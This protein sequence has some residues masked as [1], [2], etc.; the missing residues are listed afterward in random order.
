M[1]VANQG[2][3]EAPSSSLTIV[4]A[5]TFSAIAEVPTGTGAHGVVVEPSG[6]YAYV[7]DIYADTVTIV[8]VV[9]ATPAGTI[10][11][12]DGPNG[13]SFSSARIDAGVPASLT[14]DLRDTDGMEGEMEH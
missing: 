9:S 7:T 14:V 2:T 8:D 10:A 13:I 4:D 5:T 12:G 1:L 6:R 11:V 3:E